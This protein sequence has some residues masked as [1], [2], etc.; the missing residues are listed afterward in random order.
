MPFAWHRPVVSRA[1]AGNSPTRHASYKMGWTVG[2]ESRT[3]ELAFA[4]AA[5]DDSAVLEYYDQPPTIWLQYLSSRGRKLPAIAHTP[6]FFVLRQDRAEWVECKTED[7]L[8]RLMAHNPHRYRRGADDAWS[9][10]PGDR[11]AAT[12]GL[13][14]RVF[15]SREI[16]WVYQRNLIFLESYRR[17]PH[18]RV[19]D[20]AAACVQA[21]VQ[22]APGLALAALLQQATAAS[23]DDI[24]TLIASKRVYVDLRLAPLAEPERVRIFRDAA[25]ARAY[26]VLNACPPVDLPSAHPVRVVVGAAIAWDGAPWTIVN[27]GDHAIALLGAQGLT[28]SLPRAD[29][30]ALVAQGVITGLPL[31]TWP[32]R[33]QE[34]RDLIATASPTALEEATRRSRIVLA[35]LNRE[36]VP[37]DATPERTMYLWVK[38]WRQAGDR[39]GPRFAFVGLLPQLGRCGNRTPKLLPE[40]R[41]LAE[42][43][44]A[45]KLESLRGGTKRT[46]WG[47]LVTACGEKGLEAPSYKTF[48]TMVQQRPR[49]AH[50]CKRRGPRAAYGRE[51]F[52][53]ELTLSTPR[54]GDRPW[55]VGHIDHSPG[56]VELV[57]SR[58]GKNLGTCWMTFL[59]DAFSRRILAVYLAFHPPSALSCMMVLRECVRRHQRLPETAVV[60]GGPEF[61]SVYFET[62]LARYGTHKRT[63]PSGKPRHGSVCERLFG[64][65]MT[66]VLHG[67][68]GNTQVRRYVR[69]VTKGVDPRHHAC[70]TLE[71][72]YHHLCAW[73]YE[74]YDT[75]EHP[76]LGQS[77]R[78][79]YAQGLLAGG[80]REHLLIP[81]DED[82][83]LQTLP[84]TPRGTATVQVSR[85]VKIH[86]IYYWARDDA[87]RDPTVERTQVP[88]RYDPFD[89]GMAYAYVRGRWRP[90]I[91]EHYTRFQGRTVPE[92][93]LA[94]AEIRQRHAR[95]NARAT[96]VVTA[97]QIAA[98]LA[99]AESTE[100]ELARLRAAENRSIVAVIMGGR[101]MEAP[102]AMDEMSGYAAA[103]G[104]TRATG[105]DATPGAE[106]GADADDLCEEYV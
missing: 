21:L 22:A 31:H 54:H 30:E 86:N 99:A 36:V 13:H 62:L 44:I 63:R 25:M 2:T 18:L 17:A 97:R 20:E 64:T 32:E 53:Y 98:H 12:L 103:G 77:P 65:S 59:T 80:R 38:R 69:G 55:E 5:D 42:D 71:A 43:F 84:T 90:C 23:A 29:V 75:L 14:Y 35:H 46:I 16:D 19:P 1:A 9:C 104:A 83:V 37:G 48:W 11:Y 87:F 68:Q 72:L 94:S 40:T 100:A 73:A 96:Y 33:E 52:Y 89:A 85:G 88:V 79:T 50:E 41:T 27:I 57:C 49:Y 58:T 26:A 51:P 78:A 61:R 34:A 101:L 47:A 106:T 24:Y 76:A 56:D 82:F 67:L 4:R 10:P 105:E 70:W 15:S 7:E 66:Q 91:S 60:D 3:V 92:I 81:Y 95:H 102:P 74:V 39:Y 6:D 8:Q 45:H 28:L 93:M